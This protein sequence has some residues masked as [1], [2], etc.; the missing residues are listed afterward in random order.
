MVGRTLVPKVHLLRP[1]AVVL[2][3]LAAAA[4]AAGPG[5][6]SSESWDLVD[7]W[8]PCPIGA[9]LLPRRGTL[10]GLAI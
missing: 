9:S 7:S 4:A 1:Q 5:V 6:S 2:D 10:L 8:T 3:T